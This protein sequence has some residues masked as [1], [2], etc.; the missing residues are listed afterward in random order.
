MSTTGRPEITVAVPVKDRRD[1]MLRCLKALLELNHP[2]YEV[3]VVDNGSTD[4]TYEACVEAASATEI[5]VRVVREG[6]GVGRL[7]N[8]AAHLAHGGLVAFTDSD[9]MPSRASGWTAWGQRFERDASLGIVQGPTRP[10]PAVPVEPWCA[11]QDLP[12]WTGRF[13]CCNLVVRR[14]A[15]LGSA[16]FDEKVFFGEDTA[17]G[18]AMLRQGWRAEFAPDALVFHDVTK[19]G[20]G[21]WMRKG[22][23]YGN[24]A[25]IVRLYP[26][27]RSQTLWLGLFLER[28]HALLLAAVVGVGLSRL[29]KRALALALPYVQLRFPRTLDRGNLAGTGQRVAFEL[30]ILIGLIK[31][32][33][34]PSVAG[35]V[36]GG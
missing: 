34:R 31:G 26:E 24:F 35:T 19:P 7:R 12:E 27:V 18:L 32:L 22:F 3:L 2:S 36:T 5:P 33:G 8:R 9:C 25:R 16:G 13:E 23:A 15:L 29:D 17:A 1:R 11:T 4:G 14:E 10:D 30:A 21:W 28:Y 6:G 20:F